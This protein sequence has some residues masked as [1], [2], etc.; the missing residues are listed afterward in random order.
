M[1]EFRGRAR[2]GIS[3]GEF[4]QAGDRL[5]AIA[6]ASLAAADP[7]QV[8]LCLATLELCRSGAE[9][10]QRFFEIGSVPIGDGGEKAR[11]FLLEESRTASVAGAKTSSVAP[12]GCFIG[13]QKEL[14][15]LRRALDQ[16]RLV[17]LTGPTGI[18]K[19]TLMRRFVVDL[20]SELPDG[21]WTVDLSE[22]DDESQVVTSVC[23]AMEIPRAEFEH[24]HR[25]I[26]AFMA[27]K[28]SLLVFD[29]CERWTDAVGGLVSLLLASAEGLQVVC[30]SQKRLRL[31]DEAVFRLIGL[32]AP[33]AN[34][35]AD[36]AHEFDAVGLFIE[37]AQHV[38]SSFHLSAA[39][40]KWV[41][42]ICRKLEGNPLAIE[43]AAGKIAI[44]TPKQIH[45]R[46][47]QRFA[48]LKETRSNRPLRHRSLRA[49]LDWTHRLLSLDAQVLLRRLSVLVGA[50]SIET[51]TEVCS[52]PLLPEEAILPAFEELQECALLNVSSL[53]SDERNFYL[54]ETVRLYAEEA[55]IAARELDEAIERKLLWA[56][57]FAERSMAEIAGEEYAQWVVRL[58]AAYED[59]RD[60]IRRL[61][62]RNEP[63]KAARIAFASFPLWYHRGF[64]EEGLVVTQEVLSH[65][66]IAGDENL[67]RYQNMMATLHLSKG[68]LDA[69][70]RIALRG[71]WQARKMGSELLEA[72]SRNTLGLVAFRVNRWSLARL[73]FDRTVKLLRKQGAWAKLLQSLS[74]LLATF[75]GDVTDNERALAEEAVTLARSSRNSAME[76][77][78]LNNLAERELDFG[79]SDKAIDLVRAALALGLGLEDSIFAKRYA[80]TYAKALHRSGQHALALRWAGFAQRMLQEGEDGYIGEDDTVDRL[81]QE[82]G[83][84]GT[85]DVDREMNEGFVWDYE[86]ARRQVESTY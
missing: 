17:S 2:V 40:T 54:R 31:P 64:Y 49:M 63:R 38:E 30:I 9:A 42:E 60:A 6:A 51:A 28:R 78:I 21:I 84:L 3:S 10:G 48:L 65:P 14:G 47:E 50:Y 70:R 24:A 77:Q 43:L 44:L 11:L 75:E 74:N 33:P 41:G 79:R 7:G 72:P 68:D 62:R 27:G 81:K 73:H 8:V 45:D 25:A 36:F 13:R 53:Q 80:K 59:F 56:V 18:G 55:L 34:L 61:L 26:A 52:D 58:D 1:K 29:G 12:T 82:I 16:S 86:E 76:C 22:L 67:L 71:S 35:D 69:A 85:V 19:T 15:Q 66:G 5:G 4:S 20:E 23:Q 37:R 32:E 39:N 57:A 46:L 83:L